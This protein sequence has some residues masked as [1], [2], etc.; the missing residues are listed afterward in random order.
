MA[1]DIAM[2]KVEGSSPFSRFAE[3]PQCGPLA[4]TD[5]TGAEMCPR[6]VSPNGTGTGTSNHVFAPNNRIIDRTQG[7]LG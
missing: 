4:S 7:Q 3:G 6:F 5:R 2:Q 1:D